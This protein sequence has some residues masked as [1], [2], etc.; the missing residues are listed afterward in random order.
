MMK[1]EV[2]LEHFL[3]RSDHLRPKNEGEMSDGLSQIL[4]QALQ[5]AAVTN[6][7]ERGELTINPIMCN[8]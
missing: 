6:P 4:L 7:A 8:K 3:S 5:T 2:G 1:D